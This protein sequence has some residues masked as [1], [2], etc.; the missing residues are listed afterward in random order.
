[1]KGC[2]FLDRKP[3]LL[4]AV[5]IVLFVLGLFT[6]WFAVADRYAIF[7]Y[8][9]LGATPFD[10]VTSSRYWM[11][12]L[13]AAGFVM[14][15]YTAANWLLG[16]MAVLR[17]LDYFL[18]A[19]WRVWILCAPPLVIGIP[20]I[21]MTVNWPTLP[22]PNATACVVATLIG[23][24]L[25]LVPGSLAAQRPSDLGWLVLDGMGM[26]PTLLLLRAIELPGRGLV[27]SRTAYLAAFGG[28]FMGVAWLGVMTGLRAWRHKSPPKA[29][30]LFVAGLCLSYVLMP[31]VHHLVFT[32]SSYRYISTASN[33]FPR[34]IGVQLMAF[35]VA[36]AL[37]IGITQLRRL[38]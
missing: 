10:E 23:L 12:G 28:T 15:G 22:L 30:T 18:P 20:V 11:S 37:A 31:L 14:V 33:F 32:P 36:A 19:W 24:A 2:S 25:A 29:T 17:H 6:Y 27:S 21:T 16:R 3:A 5:P 35:L 8:G 4:H 34:S 38:R 1:M 7:L 13:V 26:M 9:H